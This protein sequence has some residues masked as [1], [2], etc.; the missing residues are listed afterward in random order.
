MLFKEKNFILLQFVPIKKKSP[1]GLKLL[2]LIGWKTDII[3]NKEKRI[4]RVL[5]MF[6][7]ISC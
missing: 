7:S 5:N 3:F 6:I 1:F 4:F 2:G